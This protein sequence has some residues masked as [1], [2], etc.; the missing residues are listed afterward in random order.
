MAQ[1]SRR[2]GP[3][4]FGRFLA[5]T[6]GTVAVMTALTFPVLIGGMALGTEASYWYLSQRKLQQA[7]DLAAYAAAVQVRSGRGR[8]DME[9]AA[10]DIAVAS[11]FRRGEDRI[12]VANP[13]GSGGLS[14]DPMAVEV[15]V[16]RQQ[17]RFF[18]LIYDTE[19]VAISARAVARVQGGGDACLLALDPIAP[20]A[21][22]VSGSSVVVFEGCDVAANSNADN[23]FLMSGGKVELTAG[24]VHSV[25]G[26][27][28]TSSLNL[29]A[30]AAPN[31]Q[32]AVIRDPY[33]DL[34]TPL[35]VGTCAPSRVGR[36][37][38]TTTETP[39]ETHP[40]GMPVR[41]YCGGLEIRGDVTFD[42]GLYIVDGG[43]LRIN[44][45]TLVKGDGVTFF[46]T[47]GA[48]LAIN[49]G[50]DLELTAPGTGP[51]A[52]ILFFGDRA[53]TGLSHSVNGTAGSTLNGAVYLPS[54]DLDYSG[55][56]SGTYGCTQVVVRRVT[57][58]GNSALN[59]DCSAAGTRRIPVSETIALVE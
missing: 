39:Y 33:S 50:A 46:L 48:T 18:S 49:G 56:F 58:T 15:V 55:N 14:G 20:G 19:P 36:N 53:D 6:R 23:A 8:A 59:V 51:L 28:A 5:E 26:V 3:R 52:G 47:N 42:A 30:C 40:L 9:A 11:A 25:G 24:C 43:P 10:S 17:I 34:A 1:G 35:N 29:T 54:S 32:S 4:R 37:N 41:R 27:S 2:L 38:A 21:I 16:D 57:F 44:A 22:T 45:S 7:S 31:E 13:P 12:T